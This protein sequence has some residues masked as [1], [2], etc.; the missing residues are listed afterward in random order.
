M[1]L[2]KF[3]FSLE[4]FAFMWP[5]KNKDN[6]NK[7]NIKSNQA[8]T[9]NN[10][11]Q[12]INVAEATTMK[13]GPEFESLGQFHCHW[14]V[15][16]LYAPNNFS[17]IFG[18]TVN[19]TVEL[20]KAFDSLRENLH[21]AKKKIGDARLYRIAQEL[22]EMSF[23]AYSAGDKKKGAHT[24]QECRGMI[25]KSHDFGVKYRV[26]AE[27]RAFGNNV[28]Y[29]GVR[30]SP[31]PYEGTIKDIGEYQAT[32]LE[33]AKVHVENYLSMWK[34]FKYFAWVMEADG[35]IKRI[36]PEPKEDQTPILRPIQKSIS[37]CFRHA[38]SLADS[39]QIRACVVMEIM[40]PQGDGL[41]CYDLEQKGLPRVSA[42]QLFKLQKGP[43]HTFEDMKFHIEEPNIF[44][45]DS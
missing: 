15:V 28:I 37:A 39:N 5:F 34:D 9:Q 40:A 17:G 13:K 21:L 4:G 45:L 43:S 1:Y 14:S 2:I 42:R 24:L 38:K 41:V 23:E 3:S 33:V 20:K 26:E 22:I 10:S 7:G 12:A 27:R 19:Q 31:Y 16:I 30:I 36:S 6:S 11:D 29:A 8:H 25:W 18:E 32:L 35:S 44:T